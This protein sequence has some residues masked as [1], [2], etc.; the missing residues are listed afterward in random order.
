MKKKILSLVLVSAM[1]A[2]LIGC[3]STSSN[4]DSKDNG[5]AKSTQSSADE[6]SIKADLTV[7]GPSE[8]QSSDNGNWLPTM[9]DAFAKE[10]PNWKLTFNYGVCAEGDAKTN[11]T[12][13]VEG[14]ADV[15]MYAND[16]ITD[17][18][19]AGALSKLGG[20][21][22]EAVKSTNSKET[23]NSVT[24]D[25]SVYGFPFTT[26]TW[27]LYYDKSKFSEDDVKNLDTMLT[28]GKVSFPLSNSWY[29]ASFYVANGGTMFGADGTDEKAGIN[30][31]G[32]KGTA[33]TNYLVDLVK[34]A[35]FVNDADGSGMAGLRDG[36]V[37][38]I[39]SGSWDAQPVKE[40]LGDNMGVAVLPSITIDGT[41]YQMKSFAGTKAIGVNPNCKNQQVAIALAQY[42]ASADAQKAHYTLR[43]VVPCNTDLL[44][45]AAIAA[46]S[47]VKAQNDTFNNT[48]IIQPFVSAM[49]NYWTPAESMGKA[50]INGEVTHDNAAQKTE[51]FNKAMNQ[52]E[53]QGN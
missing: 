28:K 11:V 45:D 47:V 27:F 51:D 9:C 23:L 42:L 53:V 16:N 10:H 31:G 49:G 48:S 39:F 12:Q 46:D 2:S 15:Y 41:A 37:N 35:N 20:S 36:S 4:S 30:F 38:A 7:W 18:V 43:N 34:N 22:L 29:L 26:N 6:A 25:K 19:S 24:L 3:G 40:A 52:S 14:A 5:S 32:D 44:K 8:D 13:D 50:L 17:L 21:A 33:V 1:A